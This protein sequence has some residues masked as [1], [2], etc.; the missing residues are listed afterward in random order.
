MNN[1]TIHPELLFEINGLNHTLE[2]T[3]STFFLVFCEVK[4]GGESLELHLA[5]NV[6]RLDY[7]ACRSAALQG[8]CSICSNIPVTKAAAFFD[9]RNITPQPQGT[10]NSY[11]M[12]SKHQ[13]M[14]LFLFGGYIY[15]THIDDGLYHPNC[16]NLFFLG[17]EPV[18]FLEGV[19]FRFWERCGSGELSF[20]EMS[21]CHLCLCYIRAIPSGKLT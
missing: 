15:P 4:T 9:Q 13:V 3:T 21:E 6:P 14:F 8:R 7:S 19:V 11:K 18:I 12:H 16:R 1:L 17:R 20:F 10:L 5:N 2:P